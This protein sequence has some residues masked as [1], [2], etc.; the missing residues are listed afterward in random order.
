[1]TLFERAIN[2]LENNSRIS[3][4]ADD[5]LLDY[6]SLKIR[7][8]RLRE[9]IS[10]LSQTRRKNQANERLEIVEAIFRILDYIDDEHFEYLY[11][12]NELCFL[13]ERKPNICLSQKNATTLNLLLASKIEI[14]KEFEKLYVNF[15][16]LAK[17]FDDVPMKSILSRMRET[18][19]F[20]SKQQNEKFEHIFKTYHFRYFDS[21]VGK[22][23]TAIKQVETT[24]YQI[25]Q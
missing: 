25:K 9:L 4:F 2:N 7:I 15:K 3:S 11:D 14:R 13:L 20:D 22:L 21:T 24:L 17:N 10:E 6:E 1:M 8:E 16:K 19:D 12:L 5:V 23:R 18:F